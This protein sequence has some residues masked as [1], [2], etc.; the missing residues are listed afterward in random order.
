MDKPAKLVISFSLVGIAILY[1]LSV[2]VNP[3]LVPLDEVALHEGTVIRTRGVLTAFS[4]T[5]SGNVVMKIE[6]NGTELLIFVNSKVAGSKEVLNLSY[7]DELELEGTVEVYRG[8]YELVVSENAI[9]KLT[10]GSTI[11][12]VAQIAM[13]PEAYKGRKIQVAGYV[14]EIYQRVFYLR[15]ETGTYHLRVKLAD[16]HMPPISGLQEG[17]LII[18]EGVLAYDARTMRYELNLVAWK[19]AA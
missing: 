8:E 3:P 5:E 19:H 16:T 1:T 18:A 7:G 14:E 9:K 17:A 12:F 10:S 13:D 6:G 4:L 11:S 15:D 2:V